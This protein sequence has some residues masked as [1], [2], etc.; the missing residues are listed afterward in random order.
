MRTHT[1][2]KPFEC[3]I[4]GK[5]FAQKSSMRRHIIRQHA[6]EKTIFKCPKC[7][8]K[9]STKYKLDVHL[10]KKHPN[11]AIFCSICGQAFADDVARSIHMRSIHEVTN[12]TSTSSC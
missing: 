5:T 9:Y 6:K 2:E 3:N 8:S 7:P 4:C 1:G 12:A 10:V 11:D